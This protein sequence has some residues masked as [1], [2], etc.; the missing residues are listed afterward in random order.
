MLDPK[1]GR[2]FR[3]L[4][5]AAKAVLKYESFEQSARVIFDEATE[6]IGAKSGYIALLSED[7]VENEVLFL[8][9]GGLECTVDPNLPMPIRGLREQCYA[10]KTPV[11]DNDFM[12][13]E[14]IKYLPEGHVVLENVMFTPLIIGNDVVGVIGMANKPE[15]FTDRDA[16]LSMAFGEYASIALHNARNM[17][18]LRETVSQLE[19]ALE[20]V[21]ILSGILP[22]CSICHKIKEEEGTW[23]KIERYISKHSEAQFSHGYCPTCYEKEMKKLDEM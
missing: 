5:K 23:T 6:L 22:V 16:E 8:E 7:G 1:T 10:Q 12:K 19:S 4:L 14:W 13:S 9:A 17:D 2:I 11:F 18:L 3:G 21:K 15:P 20:K